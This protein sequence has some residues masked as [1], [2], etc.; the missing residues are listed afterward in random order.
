MTRVIL[1][2]FL[3][4]Q[5][6]LVN[7]QGSIQQFV[8]T[9]I[10]NFWVAYK[11]INSTKDSVLQYQY[12][13]ELYVDKG[14]A[15]LNSLREVR[16]YTDKEYVD[17]ILNYPKFWASIKANTLKVKQSYP[18]I[19]ADIE[20]LRKAYPSLTPSTIY[21][22][23][24]VFRTGGTTQANRVLIG[25]ELSLADKKTITNELPAW[26]Q[27]FYKL[28]N[29]LADLALLC[30]HEYIH[31]QQKEMVDNLQCNALREGIAEY[32]S[33]LVTNK[34]SNTPSFEFGRA[35]EERVKQK[36]IEDLF[37]PERMYSWMWGENRNEFK[38]RDLGYYIGYRIC[39]NYYQQATNKEQAIK[40]LIELDYSNDDALGTLID[41]S[42]FFSKSIAKINEEYEASRPKVVSIS[43]II[44]GAKDAKPGLTK[45]TVTFSEPLN[46]RNTGIDFGPLGQD[47]C[48]AIK[49]ERTWSADNKTWTF[50]ADLKP[51]KRYQILISE[52]FRKENGVRLK[53]YLIDITTTE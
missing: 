51:G 30:T 5:A 15:G 25:C 22:S 16:R 52:N 19:A 17:A 43:P 11:K 47:H 21:F 8:A 31:T 40:D 38:V 36:F 41:K 50:E 10:D 39:E 20:K 37:L 45:I 26:R 18:E 14:T 12:L 23:M 27:P 9:D 49:P 48:P 53:A 7:G 3:L 32:I 24:G 28:Y 29:P 2:F 42:A 35:N 13:K 44:N 1:S 46:G 34:P 33:C 4:T 6:V